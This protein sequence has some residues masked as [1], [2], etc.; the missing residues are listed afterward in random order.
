MFKIPKVLPKIFIKN[1]IAHRGYHNCNG[2]FTKGMGPENS[3][4][5]ILHAIKEGFSIEIDIRFTKDYVP[6]VVHD[7][8]LKRLCGVDNYLSDLTF[9]DLKSIK[10]NNNEYLPTLD[11]IL[12][13]VGGKVPIYIEFKKLRNYNDLINLKGELFCLLKK[14][15]GP[16]AIMSF[17]MKLI[18]YF[19]QQD[20][21]L[22]RGIILENYNAKNKIYY[23][24]LETNITEYQM[25][26]NGISFISFRYNKLTQEIYE[27]NNRLQRK[28]ITWTVNSELKA[29]K[30]N[31]VSDNITFE[32]FEPI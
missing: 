12:K 15:S 32:G 30:A 25:K 7:N 11:E 27:L 9:N 4:T 5:S 29:K 24:K 22:I 31:E 19:S 26:K 16:L 1:P 18:A 21:S 20:P 14:Y 10:L 6:I 23:S 28:V 8:N 17:D 13:I 2:N 3:R